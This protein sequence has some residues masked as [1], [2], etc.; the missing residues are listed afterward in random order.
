MCQYDAFCYLKIIFGLITV[1]KVG[2]LC[3]A[4]VL[5]PEDSLGYFEVTFWSLVNMFNIF[6]GCWTSCLG[7][8]IVF[9]S[10]AIQV[11]KWLCISS[12][13]TVEPL[14]YRHPLDQNNCSDWWGALIS[15]GDYYAGTRTNV[16]IILVSLFQGCPWRGVPLY[17]EIYN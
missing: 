5:S 8:C 12:V 15:G 17:I 4:G 1:I 6:D 14:Y 16:L 3:T 11:S 13:C 9:L 7:A 2:L 10:D